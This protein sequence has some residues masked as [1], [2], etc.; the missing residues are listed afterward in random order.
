M[1]AAV[2][3]GAAVGQA[4]L[5]GEGV[6]VVFASDVKDRFTLQ[7]ESGRRYWMNRSVIK[8]RKSARNQPQSPPNRKEI[9]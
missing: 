3:V 6:C 5:P 9:A 2:S 4:Y 7:G 8:W 1:T